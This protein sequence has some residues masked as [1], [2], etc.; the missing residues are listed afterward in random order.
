L[1]TIKKN[2]PTHLHH[3]QLVAFPV[4]S[5]VYVALAEESRVSWRGVVPRCQSNADACV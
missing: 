2:T 4:E 3:D 1:I 5:N